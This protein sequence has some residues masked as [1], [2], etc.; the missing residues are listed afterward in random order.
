MH[1]V[2][3]SNNAYIIDS[4]NIIERI[5][6]LEAER[7]SSET[8]LAFDR[9]PEGAELTALKALAEQG[10]GCCLDW[11]YGETL[12]RD[13]YF[14]EYAR[15]LADDIGAIQPNMSWPYTCIDWKQAAKDLKEDYTALEYD[16]VTYW[17]R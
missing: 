9:E 1:T 6:D 3:T 13:S 12:I 8:P 11:E 4:R 5:A 15:E 14:E 16:G 2:D 7:E 17:A 10:E